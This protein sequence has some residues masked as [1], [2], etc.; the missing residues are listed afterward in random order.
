MAAPEFTVS[1]LVFA[2]LVCSVA[3]YPNG[4]VAMSCAG[5]TPQ[6]GHSPQSEPVHQITVSQ[7]RFKPG[8]QIQVTL[9]GPQFRGF[10]LEARDAEDLSGPPV[11]SFTLIDRE[12]SQLLT[13][14]DVQGLAVSHTSSSK[15]TEVKVYWNAPSSAPNH[16]Q[17]LATVVEKYKIYWV[18]IPS[19]VI[20]QPNAPPFTTPKA[21]APPLTT[22]PSASQLTKPF[23]ASECGNKKFCVRSPLNCDPESEPACVFLSF[24]KDDPT[25]MIEMSG[26]SEGYLSFAFSH[27]RWMGDDDAYLC[28]REDQTVYIRPSYLTGRSYPVMDSTRGTLEDMAWRLVDGVIQ[29]SFRRNITLPGVKNRFVLNESYYIFLA[30]GAAH[31]GRIFRHHEQPLMTYEKYDVTGTPKNVGGS[32]SSPLLKAHGALMFVAW[33]TTVSIG[34][35][36]ARF[37]R[38]VWSKA[39]FLGEAVWFQ[40]HRMLMLA[41]SVLTCIAFVMP[42]V[43]RG[44]W[45]RRAGYHPYLGCTVMT[46]AV[47]QPLLAIFRPPLHDPRRQVFNWTHWSVGTATRIIAVAAMFLGMDLPGLSLP[48]PQKTYA[49]MGF[50]VWHIGTE[51]LL[52]I[53]AYRLSRKVEILDDDRIQILQSLTVAEAEGHVFKK[54]V[55]SIYICGNVIFLMIFLSAINQV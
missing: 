45:S 19:H 11:G 1:A 40:V 26:P 28:I 41:T 33:M 21:T 52:E 16:I 31:D 15:K 55:L 5:M 3:G 25:V 18:K 44:G 36:V 22:S 12:V 10:L 46:L 50:V 30:E 27:D 49:M 53:H 13:C 34:V 7:M 4:K 9:S 2:V 54:A 43:Y 6:H 35:L 8:D 29:C 51:V 17:F 20:S 48:G 39:F 32:H 47:L 42:F 37:F 14:E 24:T 23:S 38:S